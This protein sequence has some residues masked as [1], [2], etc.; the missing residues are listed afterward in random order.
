MPEV[1]ST[2]DHDD[3]AND[4]VVV[5]G[6]GPAG[7]AAATAARRAGARVVLVEAGDDVGGQYWRHLPPQRPARDE[8]QLHHGWSRFTEMRRSLLADEG[9]EVLTGASVWAVEARAPHLPGDAPVL[10]VV[11]API[12]G[13]D[14][15]QREHRLLRPGAL[16]V[17][18]GA[19]DLT[20]PFPGWDLPG[21]VTGGA[22]QAFAKSE[23]LAVGERVVVAGAGPFLLPVASSLLST[24]A[25]VLEVCEAAG[26]AQLA[27][28]W[29]SHPARLLAG[30]RVMAAKTAELAGYAAALLRER[31]PYRTAT[32]V[33]AARG[34]GRLEEVV[35]A[36]LA[37]DWSPVPG[38]ERVV[39]ADALAV[40]HG[41]TP[42]LEVALAAGCAL[43]ED[44]F[45]AVDDR[46][47]T[48]VPGVWAAGEVTGIG[49]ADLAQVEGELAGL[50]AAGAVAHPG[51]HEASQRL[52]QQL[53][54]QVSRLLDR[55]RTL[56]AFAGRLAAA[57]APRAGWLAQVTDDT[58][59]C[60][61]EEVTAGRLRAVA[62]ATASTADTPAGAR[63]LRLTTRAGLGVC[64]G[65]ICGHAVDAV[66]GR[67]SVGRGA[68][69]G[70]GPVSHQRR[71]IA[72][73]VRLGELAALPA[74]DHQTS[75][76]QT[77]DHQTADHQTSDHQTPDLT[78]SEEPRS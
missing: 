33:V 74:P 62:A 32:G 10:R 60:R 73:P 40:S 57:H 34:E 24:G 49:G 13:A 46:G 8:G 42:R 15:A 41:F 12:G 72:V 1:A 2:K 20:L 55:R 54:Q 51:T 23:R 39:A 47:A 77:A 66:L 21:V 5:V 52:S 48:S 50:A 35:L 68:G 61:C 56:E 78:D 30:P 76:H 7:L 29:G 67:T 31:V 22:A 18:T 65:R 53:S 14:A 28:G 59:V 19:H 69:S 63:S 37:P 16:V 38:T 44:G 17:A 4:G 26:P 64:Q 71:P 70:V 75:D 36:R 45:V 6:G 9:C 25:T 58:T 27:R 11:L 3:S 43:R